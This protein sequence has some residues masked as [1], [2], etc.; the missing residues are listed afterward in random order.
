MAGVLIELFFELAL[1]TREVIGRDAVTERQE[2]LAGLDISVHVR[3]KLGPPAQDV[4]HVL[5]QV[6]SMAVELSRES[7][8]A[9]MEVGG[10]RRLGL[11]AVRCLHWTVRPE[12][13]VEGR[14]RRARGCQLIIRLRCDELIVALLP[15][16]RLPFRFLRGGKS[17]SEFLDRR[18]A[19]DLFATLGLQLLIVTPLQKVTSSSH[20]R[21]SFPTWCAPVA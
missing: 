2:L 8:D 16:F 13:F 19:L 20:T 21:R 15:L 4:T 18:Y 5:A 6:Q 17:A 11:G 7:L 12:A 3:A 14:I 1:E 9:P 10:K